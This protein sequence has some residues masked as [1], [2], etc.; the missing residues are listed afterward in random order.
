MHWP[1]PKAAVNTP[2]ANVHVDDGN[3]RRARTITA[4]AVGRKDEP[5]M[6]PEAI[7]TRLELLNTGNA[8]PTSV[9]AMASAGPVPPET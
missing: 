3:I 9:V 2:M 4:V 6:T 8:A 5:K 7:A 1:I